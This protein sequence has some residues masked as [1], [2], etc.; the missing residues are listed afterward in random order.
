[1]KYCAKCGQTLTDDATFCMACGARCGAEE[2]PAPLATEDDKFKELITD[3]EFKPEQGAFF[4]QP[5]AYIPPVQ[6][7]APP[8][9]YYD[10]DTTKKS[11]K[12]TIIAII[13]SAIIVIAAAIAAVFLILGPNDSSSKSDNDSKKKTTEEETTEVESDTAM[14]VVT[15]PTQNNNEPSD[16]TFNTTETTI[17]TT[18][19]QGNVSTNIDPNDYIFDTYSIRNDLGGEDYLNGRSRDEIQFMINIILARHG[20]RFANDNVYLQF[21]QYSWYYADTNDMSVAVNRLS[22]I[23]KDNYEYLAAYRNIHF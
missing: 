13:I 12:G 7:Y 19:Y 8:V 2:T 18:A 9:E 5:T 23:E 14:Q 10:D 17:P 4:E 20:Y 11:N 1:M 3:Y 22:K 16:I 15:Q 21:C 6:Q